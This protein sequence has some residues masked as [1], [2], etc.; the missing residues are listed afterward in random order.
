MLQETMK[1]QGYL[2]S[3]TKK[4]PVQAG[5]GS[6][7]SLLIRLLD[8]HPIKGAEDFSKIVIEVMGKEFDLGPCRVFPETGANGYNARLTCV[9]DIY[10]LVHLF[11]SSK[12]VTL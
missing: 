6:K 5:Y 2:Q 10:D 8:E 11:Q 7:F 4:M 9:R 1:V 12:L 3:D